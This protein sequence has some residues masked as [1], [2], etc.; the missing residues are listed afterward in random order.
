MN[1]S[2]ISF[3]LCP[4]PFCELAFFA[5][6]L[7]LPPG[8]QNGLCA[9]GE[10]AI[11]SMVFDLFLPPGGATSAHGFKVASAGKTKK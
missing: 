10:F 1:D 7:V 11:K 9:F 3:G 5:F 2:D 4:V 6:F 8:L